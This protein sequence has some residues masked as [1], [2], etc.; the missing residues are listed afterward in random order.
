M[1]RL[2]DLLREIVKTNDNAEGAMSR[3]FSKDISNCIGWE[4]SRMKVVLRNLDGNQETLT[5]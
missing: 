1:I 3:A 4:K 5:L 2:S